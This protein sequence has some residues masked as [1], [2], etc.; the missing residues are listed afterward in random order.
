VYDGKGR[1]VYGILIMWGERKYG[2]ILLAHCNSPFEPFMCE[3]ERI[4]EYSSGSLEEKM[5]RV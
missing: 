2:G 5:I 3:K 1:F 4:V